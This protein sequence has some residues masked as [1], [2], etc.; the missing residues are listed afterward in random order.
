MPC[1]RQLAHIQWPSDKQQHNKS[2]FNS[3]LPAD[4]VNKI[5]VIHGVLFSLKWHTCR[6]E[7]S[8]LTMCQWKICVLQKK[9]PTVESVYTAGADIHEEHN[10]PTSRVLFVVNIHSQHTRWTFTHTPTVMRSHTSHDP[11]TQ[12]ERSKADSEILL[13]PPHLR[14][15]IHWV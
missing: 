4:F 14:L 8:G 10:K 9:A 6:D 11:G 12:N 7:R 5:R 15:V 3:P 13:T 2:E 1:D